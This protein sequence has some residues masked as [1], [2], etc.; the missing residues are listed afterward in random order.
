MGGFGS[1]RKPRRTS[2]GECA[3]FSIRNFNQLLESSGIIIPLR[4]ARRGSRVQP[5]SLAVGSHELVCTYEI[6]DPVTPVRIEA[7]WATER[8]SS[9]TG[10]RL[11]LICPGRPGETCNRRS[12]VFYL[13]PTERV[14]LCRKCHNL[15]YPSQR[16]AKYPWT[17]RV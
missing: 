1:G 17:E 16:A 11:W 4:P 10:R 5:I 15:V 14:F 7:H 6:L 8:P 9:K 12:S 3:V 13:P 2:I